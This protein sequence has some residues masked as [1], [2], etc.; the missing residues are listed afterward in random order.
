M[1][2]LGTRHRALWLLFQAEAFAAEPHH[3]VIIAD[4]NTVDGKVIA[5]SLYPRA[6]PP[7]RG[8]WGHVP[9]SHLF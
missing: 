8:I 9:T 4:T 1:I 7:R 5:G 3:H 6:A 2:H